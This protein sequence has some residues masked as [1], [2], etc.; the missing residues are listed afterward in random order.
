M[1]WMIRDQG[2]P[3][4]S[5]SLRKDRPTLA[6]ML[7]PAGYRSYASG[8]WHVSPHTGPEGPKDNWPLARGFDRFY[9]T[10]SGGGD[11][12]DPVSLVRGDTPISP[13]ADPLRPAEW[14][15]D[16]SGYHFTDAIADEAVR[17]V[18]DHAEEHADDPFLLYVAFHSPRTGR[19]TPRRSG[20]RP[21]TA[22]TTPASTP[23]AR[24]GSP[25]STRAACCRRRSASPRCR[26][27]G[28]RCRRTS[29]PGRPPAW[30][31]TRRWSSRWT[32]ASAGC[33]RNWTA[34]GRP[35][36]RWCCSSATTAAAPSPRAGTTRSRRGR[37]SPSPPRSRRTWSGRSG[38][39]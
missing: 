28:R 36:T 37:R 15:T 21:T 33:W 39:I 26:G 32:R 4:Y 30:R 31:P 11:Y 19:C 3:G 38:P 35:R 22:C 25:G 34:S 8:K 9:G 2:L 29:G 1:G 13:F 6:E 17:F 16:G 5:G 12:Y 14:K 20:S 18:A 24:P 23:S 10:I 7:K 27:P